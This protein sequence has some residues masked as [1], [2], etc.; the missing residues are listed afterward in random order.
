MLKCEPRWATP[1]TPSRKTLGGRAA[2]V[3]ELLGLP[4]MPWQRHVFDV[5]L[6]L[7]EDG[8]PAYRE[9][10]ITVPRQSGK[11][12]ISLGVSC[13]RGA[14]WGPGQRIA[15]SAQTRDDAAKKLV[16][17][18]MPL[19]EGSKMS[20]AVRKTGKGIGNEHVLFKNGSRLGV[21]STKK[22]S[23]HGKT[24]DL[25][26]LDEFF[27]AV[28]NRLEQA[29]RPAQIT[30]P[31]AQKWGMSTAGTAESVPLW[32]KV[33]MGRR[34]VDAGRTDGIAYF[35]WSAPDD[36]DHADEDIWWR[37]MPALGHT[38]DIE[39]VRLELETLPEGEFRRAYLNQW[40]ETEEA[41]ISD[42]L[43]SA[44]L[45]PDAVLVGEVKFA[46]DCTPDRTFGAIAAADSL[47]CELVDHRPGV[48]WMV[49]RCLQL[50][51]DHKAGFTVDGSG[52]AGSIGQELE[53]LGVPITYLATKDVARASNGIYDDVIQCRFRVRDPFLATPKAVAG[54]VKRAYSDTWRWGRRLDAD[55]SPLMAITLA[56]WVASVPPETFAPMVA[57]R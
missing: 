13:D 29:V 35:E 45:D 44:V 38:I 17:D 27:A 25:A 11:T 2:R 34:A 48:G 54:A 30:K 42:R 31:H 22:S 47:V 19:I 33:Q 53:R 46:L 20:A 1:R 8:R 43:W 6:E 55:V 40:T 16:D 50:W 21:L 3:A 14:N 28:D 32:S 10:W 24:L 15:Y 23:G 56:R 12:T 39:F 7:R 51:T 36:A 52:P 26:I 41:V 5:G 57:W 49:D 37:C 9:I 18:H 4:P